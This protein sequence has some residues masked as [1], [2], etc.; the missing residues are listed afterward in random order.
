MDRWCYVLLWWFWSRCL[1]R[2]LSG[3]LSIEHVDFRKI[4]I[5]LVEGPKSETH[6]SKSYTLRV[7][8]TDKFLRG[9]R[10]CP[11]GCNNGVPV[12]PEPKVKTLR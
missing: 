3:R 2:R 5:I 11:V 1:I 9:L 8:K 10:F 6:T 7:D 4:F 12:P